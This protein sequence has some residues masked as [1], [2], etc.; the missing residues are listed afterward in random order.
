MKRLSN[1]ATAFIFALG[2]G[3]SA[4]EAGV[5]LSNVPLQTGATVPPNVMFLLDDSGSM[6]WGFM[7]DELVTRLVISGDRDIENC[8]NVVSYGGYS[9]LCALNM[10]GRN[11]LTSSH[12]NKAY[13]DPKLTYTPPVRADGS[14]FPNA[15]FSAAR[16]D[17]YNSNSATVNLLTGYRALMDDYYYRGRDS[18]GTWRLGFTVSPQANVTQAFYHNYIES[19]QDVYNNI[20]YELVFVATA[21]QQN[22]ANWF[23]YYRTRLMA[24]KAGIG[25]AFQQQGDGM[26][27]GYGAINTNPVISSG[28]R[29]FNSTHK[30]TF[31]NWLYA[32]GAT[33]ATPLRG[34]LDAAGKYFETDSPWFENPAT[35]SG[36]MLTCRQN[37]TILMTD[38]YW[39]GDTPADIG[40]QDGTAGSTITGPGNKSF[41]YQPKAPFS[42]DA[43][44]TLADVAMKYWK[45]DLRPTFDNNVPQPTKHS[46]FWQHMVTFGVG[47]GVKGDVPPEDAFAAIESGATVNWPNPHTYAKPSA[48]I[49]DLLHAAVNSQGGF[50]SAADPDT[51]AKELSKTLSQII[52][53]VAS[54]S[55]LVGATTSLETDK[56][57]FQGRF[58][59]GDWTGDLWGYDVDNNTTPKWRASDHLNSRDWQGRKIFYSKALGANQGAIFQGAISPL[60]ADQVNYIRG[61]RS[62]ELGQP[63]GVFR[64]RNSLLGDIAHSSPFYAGAPENRFYER[65]GEWPKAELDSYKPF[66]EEF[67]NRSKAV[68]VG[69]NSGMLHA[70]NSV[71]GQEIFAFIPNDMLPKLPAITNKDYQHQF[72]VDGS[73][74]VADAYIA[75]KWRS[76]LV[77]TSGRG[78]RNVFA[79]DVTKPEDFSDKSVLWEKAIPELGFY[80]GQPIIAK[81]ADSNTTS[82]WYAIMGNGVNSQN[83]TASLILLPLDGGAHTVITAATG[84]ASAPNGL[85]Q[86]EGYD[87]DNSGIVGRVYAGDLQGNVWEFDLTNGKRAVAYNGQPLFVARDSQGNRQSITGGMSVAMDGLSGNT[88]LFFG[89]GKYLEPADQGSVRTQ[90]WYG[91]ILPLTS[92]GQGSGNP[93]QGGKKKLV[94]ATTPISGRTELAQRTITNAGNARVVS[95]TTSLE[96]KRGWFMDLPDQGERITSTPQMIGSTLVMNT[97]VPKADQCSPEGYGYV[98]AIDP[99]EGVRLK[100]NF[101]DIDGNKTVDDQDRVTH[102]GQSVVASGIRFESAPGQPIFYQDIMKVSLENADVIDV[103]VDTESRLGRVSWREVVN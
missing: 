74:T 49:D 21:E 6:R 24:S 8:T 92:T 97:L 31:L 48:K 81:V 11:Y 99:F 51:F 3:L 44:D 15:S 32:K 59:S 33:G 85:S 54:A 22:F 13:Y 98:M 56:Q 2:F 4:A 71:N 12:L 39:N 20:C 93:N 76:I 90:S 17:G 70:F 5:N 28:V 35:N 65:F 66:L 62:K 16:I 87:V 58:F 102:N 27:L 36:G 18:S 77:G 72:Y 26:R 60:T 37:F 7:P 80:T 89:T 94:V 1:Q 45:R 84:S 73:V 82:R 47:L 79:L 78:G 67:K 64:T 88:W 46:A 50:F 61:D 91:L 9:N 41:Q 69:S 29:Q 52:A 57:I 83:H 86:P 30:T 10:T 103:V 23:S 53:R 68:Y 42:D 40:N 55:N 19:C 34:A 96:G 63:G 14:L 25:R 100:R 101:F 38:G 43:A 75:N 95:E